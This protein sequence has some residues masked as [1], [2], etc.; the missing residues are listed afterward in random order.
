MLRAPLPAK[1]VFRVG[2][3]R[4]GPGSEFLGLKHKTSSTL[5]RFLRGG[6][7]DRLL[8]D[9]N[10]GRGTTPTYQAPGFLDPP[11]SGRLA[12]TRESGWGGLWGDPLLDTAGVSTGLGRKA[13]RE[14]K[15]AGEKFHSQRAF[16][17]MFFPWQNFVTRPF[18]PG[19]QN[20]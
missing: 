4:A 8:S 20:I 10:D 17:Q 13:K 14:F 3:N 12:K 15:T 11:I 18:P 1:R 5:K 16:R 2:C 9:P 6:G 19:L 7:L